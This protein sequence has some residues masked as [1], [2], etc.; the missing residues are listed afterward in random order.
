MLIYSI[1]FIK[2]QKKSSLYSLV[3]LEKYLVLENRTHI[4]N[5]VHTTTLI[6]SAI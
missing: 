1:T 4:P 6:F 2:Q 3:N 5:V